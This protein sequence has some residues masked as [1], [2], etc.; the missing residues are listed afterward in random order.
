MERH[1]VAAAA[2]PPEVMPHHAIF[3][4]S[5]RMPPY[6]RRFFRAML[7]FAIEAQEETGRE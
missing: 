6:C 2:S 5:C 7:F 1:F 3:H 4:A